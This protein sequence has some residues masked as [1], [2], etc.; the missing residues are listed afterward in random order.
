MDQKT[1]KA[2]GAAALADTATAQSAAE[3]LAFAD[4]VACDGL[5]VFKIRIPADL[6][7]EQLWFR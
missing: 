7:E 6:D 2:E 3:A 5:E 1:G 4:K